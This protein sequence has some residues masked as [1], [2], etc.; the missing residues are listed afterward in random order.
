M[1]EFGSSESSNDLKSENI[2]EKL[3][4]SSENQPIFQEKNIEGRDK[5]GS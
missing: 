4:T 1:F 3:I 5:Y 2:L